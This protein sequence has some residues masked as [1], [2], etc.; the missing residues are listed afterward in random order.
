MT[1]HLSEISKRYK[2][3]DKLKESSQITP[4]S[5]T[6]WNVGSSNCHSIYTVTSW[7]FKWSFYL[8]S[9]KGNDSAVHLWS[10][11]AYFYLYMH[12]LY[13]SHYS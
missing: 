5:D 8:H 2:A 3:I 6:S 12:E 7:F 10:V 13:S 1:H 4:L 11:C 9:N